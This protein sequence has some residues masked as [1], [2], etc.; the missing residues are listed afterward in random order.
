VA[1]GNQ[2][3]KR[4]DLNLFYAPINVFVLPASIEYPEECSLVAIE[5]PLGKANFSAIDL[6]RNRLGN[7]YRFLWKDGKLEWTSLKG[8]RR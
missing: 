2:P 1:Y 8:N 5:Y 3:P 6:Y 7:F 4:K